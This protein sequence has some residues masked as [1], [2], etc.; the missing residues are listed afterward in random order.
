MTMPIL[1]NLLVLR[2]SEVSLF[3]TPTKAD[4]T[5]GPAIFLRVPTKP[6]NH[7]FLSADVARAVMRTGRI[8]QVAY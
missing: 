3:A 6:G 4:L 1:A 7:I 8:A 5:F 2:K